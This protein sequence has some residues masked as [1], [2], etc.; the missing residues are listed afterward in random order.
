MRV[1]ISQGFAILLLVAA[2]LPVWSQATGSASPGAGGTQPKDS[3]AAPAATGPI[4][5]KESED[6]M[7]TPTPVNIEGYPLSL[8][9]ESERTNYL[10]GGLR[11]S[12]TYD[13]N[14][15]T[16]ILRTTSDVSYSIWPWISLNQS[17]PRLKWS[18]SYSPGFTFYQKAT[19]LNEA[20]HA[21]KAKLDY[22]LSP[23]VTLHL[24]DVFSKSSNFFNQFDQ[25]PGGSTSSVGLQG[26]N[27]SV[28]P[29]LA[30]RISN[31]GDVQLTYQFS[32]RGMVGATGSFSELRYSDRTQ[33]GGLRDADVRAGELFYTHRLSG[34]HYIG[35]TY[36]YQ[37]L[38]A[39]PNAAET[40]T[41]SLALFY[42]IYFQPTVSLSVFG[43]PEYSDTQAPLA[44]AQ[45]DLS[46]AAG[47]SLGWQGGRTSFAVSISRRITDGGGL[48]S[49]VR[50][51]DARASF[52]RQFT[53]TLTGA[54]DAGY[55]L[56][57]LLAPT[58]ESGLGGH[59]L[60]GGF[61]VSQSLGPRFDLELGYTRLHQS[62]GSLPSLFQADRNRA[63]IS[64]SYRFERPLGR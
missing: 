24:S 56:N 39:S 12:S 44:M 53:K 10:R 32:E 41:H 27:N 50:V 37:D 55:V 43:G 42:T 61:S 51:E 19:N 1:Q 63:S 54:L 46:T 16:N 57:H 62:Y 3:G 58:V 28:I 26:Q 13:D 60:F 8:G 22:R 34:S 45:H 18:F 17:R 38:L 64:L 40:Q 9:A 21:S 23:N 47:G 11:F 33:A 48:A 7:V 31:A 25:N 59:T 36:R 52:R 30:D 4:E 29:P 5:S 49:A 15:L 2:T 20:D 35:V 14:V 6:R